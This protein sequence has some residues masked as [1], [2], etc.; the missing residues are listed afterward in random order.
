[1][2]PPMPDLLG[3]LTEPPPTEEGASVSKRAR[4][5]RWPNDPLPGRCESPG[6]QGNALQHSSMA[7][8]PVRRA[9]ASIQAAAAPAQPWQ[10]A[11]PRGRREA[12]YA[13][14]P[15]GAASGSSHMVTPIAS[16]GTAKHLRQQPPGSRTLSPGPSKPRAQSA[17]P[18]TRVLRHRQRACRKLQLFP[19]QV[20]TVT[21]YD[22]ASLRRLQC[23]C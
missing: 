23:G 5:V 13:A 3:R 21:T 17:P 16:L 2:P 12:S 1:M 22:H 7:R 18:F 8:Q 15:H 11:T 14:M 20:G 9:L 10:V 19:L 6:G 4:R